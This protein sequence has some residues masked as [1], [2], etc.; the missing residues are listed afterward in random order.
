M[1]IFTHDLATTVMQNSRCLGEFKSSCKPLSV[2]GAHFPPSR[3]CFRLHKP[4]HNLKMVWSLFFTG[5]E[6]QEGS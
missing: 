4:T 5:T 1:C 2:S 3:P 6:I